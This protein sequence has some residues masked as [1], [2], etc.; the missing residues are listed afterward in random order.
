VAGNGGA[1]ASRAQSTGG[2]FVGCDSIC[3]DAA[4]STF[5][6]PE[7]FDESRYRRVRRQPE[8]GERAGAQRASMPAAQA[9]HHHDKIG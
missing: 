9:A 3:H 5:A 7:S 2:S 6:A 1:L 8:C 4:A